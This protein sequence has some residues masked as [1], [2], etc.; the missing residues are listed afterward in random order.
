VIE[1][2]DTPEKIEEVLRDLETKINPG[3]LISWPAQMNI[4]E[5]MINS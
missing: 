4:Q 5:P 1:F 3:H 2:F